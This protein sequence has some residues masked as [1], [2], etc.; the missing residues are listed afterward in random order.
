R[1]GIVAAS[2]GN[3][4]LG[5]AYA[6]AMLGAPVTICV[7]TDNNP[8][9]NAAIRGYGATLVEE[10][11]DYDES[12]GVAARLVE[13]RGM[14][15]AHST[16]DPR[17]IAGAATLTLELVDQAPALDDLVIAVGGGSQA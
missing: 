17:V 15:L 7:P 10:G 3:H 6:G 14:L 4:G 9:K 5:L 13:E 11:R 12:V 2:K 1:R 16:N 8:E